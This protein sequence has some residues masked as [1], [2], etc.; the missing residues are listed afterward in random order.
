MLEKK[1][2]TYHTRIETTEEQK[3]V[4]SSFATLYGKA[5]RALFAKTAAGARSNKEDGKAVKRDFLKDFGVTARQYNSIARGLDGKIKSTREGRL[6]LIREAEQRI[7]TAKKVV[8][9]L[10]K[11]A[12]GTNR[13]HQKKR[14]VAG[15]E[16][17]LTRMRSDDKAGIVRLCFGSK[18]LFRKQFDL[19][20]NGYTDHAAWKADWKASRAQ[21]FALIGSKDESSGNQSCMA[22]V[23][24][25]GSITL[26]LRL[27]DA[28]TSHKRED[29]YL[30]LNNINFA[31]GQEPFFRA[32]AGGQAVSYRFVR[33]EKGWKVFV[34]LDVA[35]P[36][37]VSDCALGA[38][39]VD[40][41]ADHLAVSEIDRFG[42]MVAT[43][44]IPCITYGKSRE[45]RRATL[46]DAAKAIAEWAAK[47]GKPVIF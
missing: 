22:S 15:L 5:E 3:E 47:A 6:G 39:G 25:N 32:L 16:A 29:R 35:A 17:R 23:G 14:R 43:K 8:Q 46:G 44:K 45:Q 41:N 26:R 1:I 33:D 20:A 34:S 36:G 4:L 42:N 27:P 30:I 11:K 7:A 18:G 31:Y 37:Q 19:G 40:M 24:D 2:F 38:I 21:E 13:L 12:P 9:R 10:E 28:L